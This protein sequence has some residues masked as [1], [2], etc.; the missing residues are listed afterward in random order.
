[1]SHRSSVLEKLIPLGTIQRSKQQKK[2]SESYFVKK[3][4]TRNENVI[5]S[6]FF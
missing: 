5:L 6:I 4:F 3:N 1:M 2:E